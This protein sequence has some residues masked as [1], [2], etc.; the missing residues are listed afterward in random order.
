M[1]ILVTGATGFLGEHVVKLLADEGQHKITTFARSTS[2]ILRELDVEQVR[3]DI[4]EGEE[5]V[6]A[7]KNC[8]TVLH[9]AGVVSRDPDDSQMM[10]RIHV[11]GTRRVYKCA[12]AAGVRRVVV[13]SSSG[14]IAVSKE[15]V[16]HNENDDYKEELVGGWAYY[17]SKIYQERV[18][19]QLGKEL[20]IDTVVVNPSLLL[21]PGDRRLSSTKDVQR[22][23]RGQTPVVPT[24]GINFVDARD[25][26]KA[27]VNAISKGRAGHRYLLGGPN[28]SCEEFLNRLARAA[29]KSAPRFKLP[30]KLQEIGAGLIE[31]VFKAV[32]Q[33]PPV[34][35]I[36]A[37]MGQHHWWCDSKKAEKELDFKQR[38]P[39]ITLHD[40]IKYLRQGLL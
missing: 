15:A 17:T 29:Q 16:I 2:P 31:E 32:G 35:R 39:S 10:M 12:A 38:E 7:L 28:W 27:T 14:T 21:G 40:T 6:S 1:N 34:D 3:G 22:F 26:A 33:N 20:K 36:S 5:L 30:G 8:D 18:A 37:E 13:S 4:T 23:L 25:A 19:F 11:D 24:G 9:L